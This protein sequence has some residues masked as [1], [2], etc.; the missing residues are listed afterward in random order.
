MYNRFDKFSLLTDLYELTMMNG[1]LNE[2]MQE[3]IAYFEYYFREIPE[4]GGYAISCGLESFV[5][6]I[7]NLKFSPDEVEMLRNKNI[8]SESFLKKLEKYKFSADVWRFLKGH[9][10]LLMNL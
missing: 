6:Y 4:S 8:F 5:E 3:Q 9:Q 10:F 1:Y 2:D 7:L